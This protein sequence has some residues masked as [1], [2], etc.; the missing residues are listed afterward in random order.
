M[1]NGRIEPKQMT[2]GTRI[3]IAMIT[4]NQSDLSL[5]PTDF[6]SSEQKEDDVSFKF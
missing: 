3:V 1:R 5:S 6:L 4:G 2:Q